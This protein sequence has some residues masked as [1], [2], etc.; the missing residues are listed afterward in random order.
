MIKIYLLLISCLSSYILVGQSTQST[1]LEENFYASK[2]TF[3]T[4]PDVFQY[5]KKSRRKK[6]TATI[7]GAISI[8][9]IGAG[10]YILTQAENN[11]QSADI[12]IVAPVLGLYAIGAGTGTAALLYSSS[13]KKHKRKTL[14]MYNNLY[15]TGNLREYKNEGYN[16]A[17]TN[18]SYGL[19]IRLSF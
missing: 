2:T 4:N 13:A 11:G 16:I 3:K 19:G 17:V 8:A 10:T 9:S 12:A 1:D 15:D 6:R 14:D 7:L 18:N 5:F